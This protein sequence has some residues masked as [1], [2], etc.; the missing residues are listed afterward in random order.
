MSDIVNIIETTQ[1]LKLNEAQKFLND[2]LHSKMELLYKITKPSNL[3]LASITKEEFVLYIVKMRDKLYS[4][5]LKSKSQPNYKNRPFIKE[6]DSI[7]GELN[8]FVILTDA[9]YFK[10]KNSQLEKIIK[11]DDTI[12]FNHVFLFDSRKKDELEYEE[13][14]YLDFMIDVNK[15]EK[16]TSEKQNIENL[17][18]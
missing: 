14:S 4:I 15:Y 2:N 13:I 5:T 17:E 11:E 16:K 18:K 1:D 6:I 7:M 10:P 12:D 9:K 3:L 8:K